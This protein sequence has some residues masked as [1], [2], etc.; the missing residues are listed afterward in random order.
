MLKFETL[1]EFSVASEITDTAVKVKLRR[2][3]DHIPTQFSPAPYCLD[4]TV[5]SICR[6]HYGL[7]EKG[8]LATAARFLLNHIKAIAPPLH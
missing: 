7:D 5:G 3:L 8:A 4:L 2:Q 1:E 6:H